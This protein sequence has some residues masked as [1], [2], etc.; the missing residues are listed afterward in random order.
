[1]DKAYQ[2]ME[3]IVSTVNDYFL[4]MYDGDTDRLRGAF[5]DEAQVIGYFQGAKSFLTVNQFIKFAE[6]SPV[7]KETGEGYDMKIVSID[8]T[9]NI[10][11]V[12]VEDLYQGLQFT[13]Y[14]SLMKIDDNWLIVNKTYRHA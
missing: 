8:M 10:A 12:K 5:A 13:D 7:P 1:M 9:G 11:V 2:D 4:G 3:L 14:L 6:G